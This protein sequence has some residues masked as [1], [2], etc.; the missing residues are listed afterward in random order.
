MTNPT[1]KDLL[2]QLNAKALKPSQ[3]PFTKVGRF[4]TAMASVQLVDQLGYR[5]YWVYNHGGTII[6]ATHGPKNAK[7]HKIMIRGVGNHIDDCKW[8]AQH[9]GE[10]YDTDS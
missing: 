9:H 3:S 4:D 5:A 2:V 1:R 6:A 7:G 8:A 10:K